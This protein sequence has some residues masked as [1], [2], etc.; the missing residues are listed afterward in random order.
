MVINNL[1]N[2]IIVIFNYIMFIVDK[3]ICSYWTSLFIILFRISD[4]KHYF[5]NAHILHNHTCKLLVKNTLEIANRKQ[6][7][8]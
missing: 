2:I 1:S 3:L 4:V 7:Y 8:N 5:I 6:H